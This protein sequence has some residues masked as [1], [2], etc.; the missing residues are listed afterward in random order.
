MAVVG[1]LMFGDYIR[2]EVTSNILRTKG[3]PQ[4]LSIMIVVLIAIIPITKIPLRYEKP[5]IA[6]T[7]LTRVVAAAPSSVRWKCSVVL[8][9]ASY[10][11]TPVFKVCPP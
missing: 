4:F 10:R 5:M 9:L 7:V 3:Y 2:D 11:P 8:I 1:L 6:L